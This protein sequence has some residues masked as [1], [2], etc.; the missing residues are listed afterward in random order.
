MKKQTSKPSQV[1]A[2][3]S[4]PYRRN[5][6]VTLPG[7]DGLCA[8]YGVR[9]LRLFGSA[10]RGGFN[11]NSSDLDFL[12]DFLEEGNKGIADRYLG[13]AE[14]LERSYNRPVDLVTSR[15][16]RN[17]YFKRNVEKTALVLYDIEA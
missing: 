13:L 8:K 3:D 16:I 4:G 12:V 9:R 15:S 7:I 2:G 5:P 11:E 10:A 6:G 17:P 14:D 1:H